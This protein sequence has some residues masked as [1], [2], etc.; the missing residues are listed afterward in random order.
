MPGINADSFNIEDLRS[1]LRNMTDAELLRFGKAA[2]SMCSPEANLG[3]H[4]AKF[5]SFNCGKQ[6][7][8]GAGGTP[9]RLR[10]RRYFSNYGCGYGRAREWPR[11]STNCRT[12]R[13]QAEESS[14][15]SFRQWPPSPDSPS[16]SER[17]PRSLPDVI[18]PIY[19]ASFMRVLLVVDVDANDQNLLQAGTLL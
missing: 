8:S 17:P 16:N 4:R 3:N 5:S 7:R 11:P 1:R 6:E 18:H 13:E 19:L 12:G 15:F 9:R 2:R 14:P 10:P